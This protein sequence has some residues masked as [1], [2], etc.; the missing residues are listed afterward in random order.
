VRAGVGAG[1]L[2]T[3][4]VTF[5]SRAVLRVALSNIATPV[6]STCG[7]DRGVKFPEV[8]ELDVEVGRELVE[9]RNRYDN[10]RE[11]PL[12]QVSSLY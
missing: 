2:V 5:G 8:V 12:G 6:P 9:V 11:A 7:S 1:C 3:A 10:Q 4:P